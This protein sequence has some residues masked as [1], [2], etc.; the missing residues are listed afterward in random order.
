MRIQ[1]ANPTK[2][3]NC[4]TYIGFLNFYDEKKCIG[5]CPVCNKMLQMATEFNK[6]TFSVINR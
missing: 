4:R 1:I 6:V 5:K 3:T 2:C